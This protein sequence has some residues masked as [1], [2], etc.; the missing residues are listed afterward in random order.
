MSTLVVSLMQING[1]IVCMHQT[2]T[3]AHLHVSLLTRLPQASIG[4][5]NKTHYHVNLEAPCKYCTEVTS[6]QHHAL[7]DFQ[8]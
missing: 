2:M 5:L 7:M 4:A 6:K 8:I 3:F 1:Y